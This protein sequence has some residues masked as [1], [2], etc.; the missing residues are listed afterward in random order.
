MRSPGSYVSDIMTRR[1]MKEASKLM[2]LPTHYKRICAAR[3]EKESSILD[4]GAARHIHPQT[5]VTD[6][7]NKTR[8]LSFTG[9]P[10]WTEGN[11]YIPITARDK[12]TGHDVDIDITDADYMGSHRGQ[13]RARP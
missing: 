7:E 9:L 1:G 3:E 5:Q 12:R 8:L 4:S 2:A 6:P 10:S 11:G 13:R